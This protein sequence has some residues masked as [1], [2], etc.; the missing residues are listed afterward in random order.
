MWRIEERQG[1]V[2]AIISTLVNSNNYNIYNFL[3]KIVRYIAEKN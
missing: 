2:K 3:K 1:R